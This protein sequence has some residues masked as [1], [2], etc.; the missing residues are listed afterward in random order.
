MPKKYKWP[1][2]PRERR[3]YYQQDIPVGNFTRVV[4]GGK[5]RD[6]P[7]WDARFFKD[8]RMDAIISDVVTRRKP[9]PENPVHHVKNKLTY[10]EVP[11][12]V[13]YYNSKDE[14][15]FTQYQ[16]GFSLPWYVHSLA[17]YDEA[18]PKA[19][20]DTDDDAFV[21]RA[22][23]ACR[24]TLK[25]NL[26]L[27]VFIAELGDIKELLNPVLKSWYKSI[28]SP[29]QAMAEQHLSYAF[30]WK[31]LVDDIG[32]ILVKMLDFT[33]NVEQYI[34]NQ[35]KWIVRRYGEKDFVP[36]SQDDWEDQG[37]YLYKCVNY[38]T[39]TI[40]RNAKLVFKYSLPNFDFQR[41]KIKALL[42]VLGLCNG[43]S[44]LWELTPFS[45]IF[46][47]II[48]IGGFLSSRSQDQVETEIELGSFVVSKRYEYKSETYYD[49]RYRYYGGT[50]YGSGPVLSSTREHSFYR[51]WITSLPDHP[52]IQAGS[53]WKWLLSTSL[54]AANYD[55]KF[56]NPRRRR[57]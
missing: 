20:F 3:N 6:Y 18:L 45:F 10:H 31:P 38:D 1:E 16:N 11:C 24:P 36:S 9:R 22:F 34:K 21:W 27:F 2:G 13:G 55:Y 14:Y 42:D 30:G 17:V 48:D 47:W 39:I 23:D 50:S 54:V 33:Y 8:A 51:R 15:A 40:H 28:H 32:K 52:G 56:N 19:L 43:W 46:D 25:S 37:G 49:W 44:S 29:F 41:D 57:R 12:E 35:N 4:V 53:G 5:L 26:D 7:A